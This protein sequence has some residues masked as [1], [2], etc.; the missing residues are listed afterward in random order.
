MFKTAGST[1]QLKQSLTKSPAGY[2]KNNVL[3]IS[4]KKK[5]SRNTI[6]SPAIR[7]NLGR[8][9]FK[10]TVARTITGSTSYSN[11]KK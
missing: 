6:K 8:P 7:P 5:C 3:A 2:P 1:Q 4:H 11:H 9:G 10:P